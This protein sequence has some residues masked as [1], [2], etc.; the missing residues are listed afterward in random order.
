MNMEHSLNPHTITYMAS[1]MFIQLIFQIQVQMVDYPNI[2]N[3][4]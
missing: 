3:S 4:N 1:L 2:S